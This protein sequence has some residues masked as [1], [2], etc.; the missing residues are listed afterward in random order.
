MQARARKA[1]SPKKVGANALHQKRVYKYTNMTKRREWATFTF[2]V[3]YDHEAVRLQWKRQIIKHDLFRK[4]W[5][6]RIRKPRDE[7]FESHASIVRTYIKN[8]SDTAS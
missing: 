8:D 6:Y 1:I 7:G 2:G 3:K 5:S 4:V